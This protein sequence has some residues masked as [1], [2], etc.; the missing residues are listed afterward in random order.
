MEYVS[1]NTSDRDLARADGQDLGETNAH[2]TTD[3]QYKS[4]R[5]HR[6]NDHT[7]RRAT[8]AMGED[9]QRLPMDVR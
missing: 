5:M 3:T 4:P 6:Q 7:E 8:G 2:L 1:P 9:I